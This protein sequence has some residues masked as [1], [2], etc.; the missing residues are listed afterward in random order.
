MHERGHVLS[1]GRYRREPGS[2][3]MAR[4]AATQAYAAYPWID[5]ALVALLVSE[6]A[7]NAVLHSTG[8]DFDV[9]CHSP[10]PL[11]GSVQIEVHDRSR[12]V[13]CPRQATELDEHGRGL[14][15]LDL[16]AAAWRTEATA[17]GKSFVVTLATDKPCPA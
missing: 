11:D 2:V 12:A 7:T 5:P 13:P 15:L 17:T 4:R 8:S 14:A 3:A 6:A 10:S 9:L 1:V 16:L